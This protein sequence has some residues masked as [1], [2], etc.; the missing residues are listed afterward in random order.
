[1]IDGLLKSTIGRA[2]VA[3]MA[4]QAAMVL[5][6][7]SAWGQERQGQRQGAPITFAAM[8]PNAPGGA[9]ASSPSTAGSQGQAGPAAS[10]GPR[11]LDLRRSSSP[12]PIS[13]PASAPISTPISQPAAPAEEAPAWLEEERV[14][15]P[16]QQAGVWYV[17]TPEP[18]Y[19]ET[20]AVAIYTAM[21]ALTE[22]GEAFDPA[23]LTAAHPTL[24]I[25]SLIQ[26]TDLTT[27]RDVIV[28]LNDRG[29]FAPGRL[30]G[31]S[32]AAA[33]ALGA[34]DGAQVHVRY[35][36]PAPRRVTQTTQAAP[37]P[38][39]LR[40]PTAVI[41]EGPIA[42]TTP[43]A[44]LPLPPNVGSGAAAAQDVSYSPAPIYT[45]APVRGGFTVQLGAFAHLE[46]AQAL[47]DRARAAGAVAIDS[48][49]TAQ[50][51]LFRVRLG[52]F[53]TAG[54]AEAARAAAARLG[55]SSGVVRPLP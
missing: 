47:R 17:P 8:A 36:G 40:G 16:Y 31:L 32:P 44:Q 14:G 3:A 6:A 4:V 34:N 7:A 19:S 18:G 5:H 11:V 45:P 51:E 35:L 13:S 30:V 43:I 49:V 37:A 9:P 29:P 27:G 38:A 23:A 10:T 25:P 24:P 50:G 1:M 54:E 20:G 53:A 22:S 39:P 52:P 28:R 42:P 12:A 26:V 33:S 48:I 2:C 15:P 55:V 21:Q 46:N 41:E